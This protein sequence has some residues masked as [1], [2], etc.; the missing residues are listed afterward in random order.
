M[1][2][3]N[4]CK[5]CGGIIEFDL[6]ARQVEC[7]S[8][9]LITEL[10]EG[11]TK[12]LDLYSRADDAWG[13]KDF[14]ESM[15]LY[16]EIVAQD[17]TQSEAH[18]GVALSRYGVGYELDP[19]TLKQM[20]VC[21]RINRDSILNDKNYLSAIKYATA[22]EKAKY[23][24]RAEEIERI[25]KEFLKIVDKE[26]PRDVFISYKRTDADGGRTID[27]QI[28]KRLY[29]ILKEKGFNVFFAE[30]SL[31][32]VGGEK[33][34]PYI[35][36]ALT[37]AKVMVLFGSCREHFEATWVKNEW[38]RFLT[39]SATDPHKTLIP[40]YI[41]CDPYEAMPKELL[42][43]Q[44]F[45]ALSPVFNEEIAD[46]IKKKLGEAK[47][48]AAP[49]AG[50][51]LA[52][53]YA[54]K[55][56]VAAVVKE[57]D[58]EPDIAAE[59]L[60]IHQGNVVKTVEYISA[61]SEYKKKMWVCA[62]CKAKN[63]HDV[64]HNASCGLSREES[65]KIARRREEV[66]KAA[67][68]K[69]KGSGSMIPYI[70]TGIIIIAIIA[71]IFN[72]CGGGGEGGGGGGIVDNSNYISTA[73]DLMALANSSGEY[74][75]KAD[76][77]L[78]G[79]DWKPIEGFTGH[80]IG[81]GYAIKNLTINTDVDNVGLFS[82]LEGRVT[83]LRIENASVTVSGVHE[84]IGILC[85]TLKS[86]NQSVM[87]SGSVTGE[88]CTNVGG[89]AGYCDVGANPTFENMTNKATVT[90]FTNVGGLFGH[91]YSFMPNGVQIFTAT[92]KNCVNEG[93][94]IGKGEYAGGIAGYVHTE[95]TGFTGES[96]L[97]MFECTNKGKVTGVYYVGGIVG[98]AK[99]QNRT[100]SRIS[101]CSNSSVVEAEAYVG[102]IAG[103]LSNVLIASCSNDGSTITA[104]AYKLENGVLNACVGG[105]VG[106]GTCI[107]N[108][109]N[110][111]D[112]N[113]T[114][115][116]SFVG[117]LMGYSNVGGNI[118]FS[119][120][121]NNGSISGHDYV[122]GIAGQFIDHLG[123]GANTYVLECNAFEN[124]GAIKGNN[125]VGGIFGDLYGVIGGFTG[126]CQTFLV[127]FKNT[128]AITGNQYVGGLIGNCET[129]SGSSY[130]QFYENTGT[131]T[132]T[133]DFGEFIGKSKNLILK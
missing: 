78:S 22:A 5:T 34:E 100:V 38:R 81:N 8:C 133:A 132:G 68:K 67:E 92:V 89:V 60:I 112:I 21:N 79:V 42:S 18:W 124:T 10:G 58:C 104:T 128:A 111:A 59:A 28:A 33:Y 114:G 102:G 39:L 25:S 116:G 121:K 19:I 40:A 70:I 52:D 53:R 14:D 26:P 117:G 12:F 4:R 3:R 127:D 23:V 120:L 83:D 31:K 122:G 85:G 95:A 11:R 17:N 45:D 7:P 41:Q 96:H 49:K 84:N 113:Y 75:L 2:S 110:N 15:K 93:T 76:V 103:M 115:G 73:E 105:F 44:A 35:F 86:P 32:E 1:I 29:L 27:S 91:I 56:K 24:E 61:D 37:S 72:T 71:V 51:K 101:D 65:Q 125:Y 106:H 126:E 130:I 77:D 13:R 99:A 108:C 74:K 50:R 55:E 87:V 64:C 119:K 131:V 20:P 47:A 43:I 66:K 97:A 94:I 123:N 109:T 54:T 57:L 129:N 88:K 98:F 80:L 9:G 30:E 16:E 118:S 90:G 36:A 62:E 63:T 48:P 82:V 46:L 69:K 107:E 6:M